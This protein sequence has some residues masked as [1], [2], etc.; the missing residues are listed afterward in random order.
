MPYLKKMKNIYIYIY[1]YIQMLIKTGIC[2]KFSCLL[3][4]VRN[5]AQGKQHHMA[6]YKTEESI[7]LRG[8]GQTNIFF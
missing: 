6:H 8:K 7:T 3:D 4:I 5:H 1:I 2:A